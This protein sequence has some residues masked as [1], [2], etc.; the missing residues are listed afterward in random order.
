[1]LEGG[2]VVG[3]GLE[4]A[5]KRG[6]GALGIGRVLA[7]DEAELEENIFEPG[8]RLLDA[9][10]AN[11][12][13]GRLGP[14]R[15]FVVEVAEH[16]QRLGV[17][18]VLRQDR[19]KLQAGA[20]AVAQP[21]AVDARLL[22]VQVDHSRAV[23]LHLEPLG[24]EA[25]QRARIVQLL[26]RALQPE[27]GL[28]PLGIDLQRLPQIAERARRVVEV[29]L[30]DRS[31]DQV[32]LGARRP[33]VTQRLSLLCSS[34]SMAEDPIGAGEP[35]VAEA[36][37]R[38]QVQ[39]AAAERQQ[40]ARLGVVG[41]VEL[42]QRL[43]G[44]GEANCRRVRPSSPTESAN[45]AANSANCARSPVARARDSAWRSAVRWCG[46]RCSASR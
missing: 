20:I 42:D 18:R 30:R 40:E 1:M 12:R 13:V 4:H 10:A 2:G 14:L 21:I 7:V 5:L 44:A 3:V 6:D 15:V 26:E 39:A 27:E 24:V 9:R 37:Q 16:L 22:E 17:R 11:Q 32:G 8:A 28:A 38:R 29:V 36:D 23:G 41:A 35:Q 46:S 31:G 34:A 25:H 43:G 19:A 33:A 45:R